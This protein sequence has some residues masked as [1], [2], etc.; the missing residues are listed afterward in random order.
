[1]G[2]QT[3]GRHDHDLEPDFEFITPEEVY[4][5]E[6]DI[7]TANVPVSTV[8]VEVSTASPKV[9]TAAESLVYI[10][11][12]AAKRKDKGKAIM[13][14]VE[15]VQKKTKLQL[16]Q[17]RLGYE[18]A[19]RLQEQ[20]D[21]E[22]RQRIARVHK[23]ANTFNAKEWDNI[24]A[25]IEADEELAQ[26]LQVEE[27]GKF[28]EVEKAR[29]LVEMI[30][31]RKRLF[32]QQ[33]AEQRRNKPMTQ[34]QQRTYMCYYIKN[35]GSHT[36]QKLKKLSFDEIKELFETT[37]KRVKDF[38]PM[39]SDRLV[40][41]ISNG[42]SKRT[43]ETELDHEGSKR[44]KTNEEQSAEE[45][46]ELSKEELHKLMMIVPVEKVYVEALQKFNRDDLDKL[47]SLVKERFSSTDP[48]ND[49]ERTLWVELKRLFEPDI[50]DIL[51]KLQRYM[52][53]PLTMRLY[54]TCGVHHVS[55]NR[56]H[57]IFMLVE[58]DYLLTRGIL[59]LMLC[60]KLQVDQYS[61][62]ANE[63]LKKIFILANRPRQ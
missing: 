49:K 60:N 30:N 46:K 52:H 31:E 44:Q 56:G 58:K 11:R 23:E 12:S 3:R 19:L 39:E 48:T 45:E 34:A 25:Q 4:T 43:A 38:V 63:L 57:D 21:E 18:E 35:M 41:K 51:W 14:E 27:R 37:M 17:E 59:T 7:S 55:T 1:M 33:R 28:S 6:P 8:G 2:A 15:P 26:K 61:E 50:D 42:S 32:A 40:P 29:L 10:R 62:M 54:D 5:V 47:W 9:K 22:E 20:L 16:K 13:K 24:Q 36:L 53:D